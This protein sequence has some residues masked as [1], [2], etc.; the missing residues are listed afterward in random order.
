MAIKKFSKRQVSKTAI[1]DFLKEVE[2][3]NILRHPNIVLYMGVSFDDDFNY[4]M[5][6]EYV[7]RGSLY[8]LLH[9]EK[10]KLDDEKVFKIAK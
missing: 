6:T 1:Q 4:Y 9:E 5:I 10:M 8:K 7:Q 3:V 2:V